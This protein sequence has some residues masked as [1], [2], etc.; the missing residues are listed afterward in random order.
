MKSVKSLRRQIGEAGDLTDRYREAQSVLPILDTEDKL[1][2]SRAT[3]IASQFHTQYERRNGGPPPGN[4]PFPVKS[5]RHWA[6]LFMLGA[7]AS[8]ALDAILSAFLGQSW[9][10]WSARVA[11]IAGALIA[12]ALALTAKGA[13]AKLVV[14]FDQPKKMRRW[15]GYITLGSFLVS[16]ILAWVLLASRSPSE[17]LIDFL[18]LYGGMTLGLL[19]LSLAFLSGALLVS[20]QEYNW[21]FRETRDFLKATRERGEI[22]GLREWIKQF[23]QP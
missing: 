13:I 22:A 10:T 6:L 7:T 4:D 21:S 11:M 8:M 18:V 2:E 19:S 23:P 9:F 5:E 1:L 12:V 16:V 20:A 17:S 14:N 15:L 3:L